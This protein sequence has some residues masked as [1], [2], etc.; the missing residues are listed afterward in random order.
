MN[1]ARMSD[2]QSPN[3]WCHLCG[4]RS[5]HH[6][7]ISYSENAENDDPKEFRSK[8]IRICAKCG[9]RIAGIALGKVPGDRAGRG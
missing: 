5:D 9:E 7:D 1:P 4:K 3:D 2:H 6:V 8:Y